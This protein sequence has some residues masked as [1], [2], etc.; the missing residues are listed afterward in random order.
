MVLKP[1]WGCCQQKYSRTRGVSAGGE[2][3][4]LSLLCQDPQG[5]GTGRHS[6]RPLTFQLVL[7]RSCS[8]LPATESSPLAYSQHPLPWR[9]PASKKKKKE[10][11]EEKEKTKT[12]EEKEEEE[13]EE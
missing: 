4:G 1:R 6:C 9:R 7:S 3:A 8:L 12:K 2:Q 11:E 13:E 10:E 5:W